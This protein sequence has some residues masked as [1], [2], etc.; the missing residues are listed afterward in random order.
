MAPKTNVNV[1]CKAPINNVYLECNVSSVNV[2]CNA[3][4]YNVHGKCNAPP[5][6]SQTKRVWD[7]LLVMK[8]GCAGSRGFA[9]HSGQ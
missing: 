8:S 5:P 6:D 2:Q 7:S 4:R 3:P 9:P 1:Q